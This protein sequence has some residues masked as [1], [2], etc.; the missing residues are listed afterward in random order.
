MDT[1]DINGVQY[2]LATLGQRL[3]A[4][5]IDG[6]IYLGILLVSAVP[7]GFSGVVVGAVIAGLYYMCQDG[8]KGGQSYGKRIVHIAVIDTRTG[9]WC[10]FGQSFIRNVLLSLLSVI[11]WIFI[12][13][14]RRQRLGDKVANTAVIGVDD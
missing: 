6:A 14:P 13:G 11:D 2:R 9:Q 10:S 7:F 12:F 4:Q 5:I 3:V 8:L 1:I